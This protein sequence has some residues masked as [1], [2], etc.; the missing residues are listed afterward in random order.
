MSAPEDPASLPGSPLT[1]Y[2][3]ALRAHPVVIIAVIVVA[4]GAAAAFTR[5]HTYDARP[6][7]S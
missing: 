2:I 4:V 3:R 1:A 6:R 7:S 5:T